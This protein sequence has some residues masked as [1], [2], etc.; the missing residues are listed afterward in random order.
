MLERIW[1]KRNTLPF[2]VGVQTCTVTME[3][4]MAVFQKIWNASTSGPSYTTL[5]HIPQGY[6]L[7]YVYC[8]FI[9]NNQ[10]LC[11]GQ[12]MLVTQKLWVWPSNGLVQLQV[13]ATRGSPHP[14]LPGWLGTRDWT[15]QRPRIEANTTG[16]TINE[17]LPNG[18]LLHS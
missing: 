2:L 4:N 12:N 10:K 13:Q 5:G 18:I 6:L 16:K 8:G 1:S 3:I 7:N 17:I 9:H 11:F 14:T 15:A